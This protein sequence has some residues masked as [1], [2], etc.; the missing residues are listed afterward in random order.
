[1][2]FGLIELDEEHAK[3]QEEVSALLDEHAAELGPERRRFG[4]AEVFDPVLIR[5]LAERGLV[6]PT[7]P[8]EEGGAGLD[9]LHQYILTYE[10]H[11]RGYEG[12]ST[13]LV[14]SAVKKY[15]QPDLVA[16]LKPKVAKGEVRFCLGYTEPD[17]GSDIAAA[18]TRAVQNGDEWVINGSKMFTTGAHMSQYIFLITRTDPEQP[19]HRGLTMFLVPTDWPGVEVH[20]LETIGEERTNITYY[21][22]VRLPDRYRIGPVNDGWTVVH[23]PLD[24]EDAF[25][26]Q[27]DGL[28]ETMGV[29]AIRRTPTYVAF[30]ATVDWACGATRPDGSHPIDDPTV[31]MRLGRVAADIEWAVCTEGTM[32]RVAG[33]ELNLRVA[34]ELGDIIGAPSLLPYEADGAIDDGDV[35]RAHRFAQPTI[36][37]GGSVEV[38]RQMIARHDLGLPRPHYPGS[39]EVVNPRR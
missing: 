39:R 24:Q 33:A 23:G 14:W 13:E 25:G 1:M 17:G 10:L 11:R 36:T 3:F 38:F 8:I 15:G 2:D 19:K 37:Y 27:S 4:A 34:T 9:R 28:T 7:W 20:A 18:K 29:W 12:G 16:E 22:D 26:Q 35:E 5:K 21:G 32:G 6:H 31:R 30:D